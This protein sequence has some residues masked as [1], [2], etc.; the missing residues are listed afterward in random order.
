MYHATWKK[1]LDAWPCEG[2]IEIPKPPLVSVVSIDYV[3]TGG[4]TLT[5]GTS[6]YRVDIPSGRIA[7][8][9]RIARA[10]AVTWPVIQDVVNAISV[11]FIAGYGTTP[12]VVPGQLKRAAKMLISHWYENREA[13]QVGTISEEIAQGF[14]DCIRD[15]ISNATQ[16]ED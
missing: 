10:Y 3:E 9:G 15:Y 7:E 8:R 13:V 16:R 14:E 4:T 12:D 11:T 1:T 6:N 2:W 5:W